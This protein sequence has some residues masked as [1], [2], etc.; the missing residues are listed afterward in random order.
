MTS[1][2]YLADRGAGRLFATKLF[3]TWIDH[4][5]RVDDP[6]SDLIAL[7][8]NS[9]R[10]T[11]EASAYLGRGEV[12]FRCQQEGRDPAG[13][14]GR[15][16]SA[17][18]HLIRPIRS[19]S[20]NLDTRRRHRNLRPP[21]GL[22]HQLVVYIRR[23]H[24]NDA[25]VSSRIEWR[26]P[27]TGIADGGNQ[28][29]ATRVCLGKHLAQQIVGRPAKLML[30]M[31]AFLLAAQSTLLRILNVVLSELSPEPEKARTA[32][33]FTFGATPVNLLRAAIAPA[34]AVPCEWAMAGEPTTSYSSATTP[35]RSGCFVSIFESITATSTSS[36]LVM[37]CASRR[38]S[39][40]TTYCAELEAAGG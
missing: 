36:P 5:Q 12:R 19:D 3:A 38:C 9:G 15:N 16:G 22:R 14:R 26:R 35:V 18:R 29:D 4:R 2:P 31:R 25:R 6:G 40:F 34:I 1:E 20:E 24:A 17:R 7:A 23:R 27:R 39:L 13:M 30:M 33:N 32:S 21:V 10:G 8:R 28:H 37:R 11:G